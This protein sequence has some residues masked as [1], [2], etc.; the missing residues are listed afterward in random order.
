M[1]GALQFVDTEMIVFV[2]LALALFLGGLI[3]TERAVVARQP[4][5]TR[6]FGLVA[7]GACLFIIMGNYVSISYLGVLSFDPLR[8]AAAIIT[9]IGFI[10]GGLIIFHGHNLHGITTAAGLWIVSGIGIVVGFGMYG[11][12]VMATLLTL[13]TLTL[14]WYLEN[15]FKRWFE[16]EV[17][18]ELPPS[19]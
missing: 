4:A 3:G 11:A 19:A 16:E 1:E 6:T 2:K 15:N 7:L 9:G 8:I 18:E 14:L 17:R 12:A 5:G 13:I 10:G